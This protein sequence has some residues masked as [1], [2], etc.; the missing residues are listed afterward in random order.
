M[1]DLAIAIP[2][3][4]LMG[5]I[6]SIFA[7]ESIFIFSLILPPQRHLSYL[8]HRLVLN[9]AAA[10]ELIFQTRFEFQTDLEFVRLF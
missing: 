3:P 10:G 8:R 4:T 6:L 5:S 2:T 1:L 7:A 9:L